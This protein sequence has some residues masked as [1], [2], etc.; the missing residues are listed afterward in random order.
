MGRAVKCSPYPSRKIARSFLFNAG[1][2]R[3]GNQRKG[4]CDMAV[5][6]NNYI[7][8]LE[9]ISG[10]KDDNKGVHYFQGQFYMLTPEVAARLMREASGSFKPVAK[11]ASKPAADKAV[12]EPVAASKPKPKRRAS[13][14]KSG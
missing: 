7:V 2:R 9:C 12:A 10:W 14:K 4:D 1:A 11:A 3:H 8:E 13:R 6:D 5:K